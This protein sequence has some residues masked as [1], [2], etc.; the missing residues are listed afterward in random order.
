MKY[1]LYARKSTLQED[2]QV[3]SIDSQIND[4]KRKFSDI[5]EEDILVVTETKSAY[6]AYERKE[7]QKMIEL[8]EKGEYQGLLSYH[9]DRLSREPMSGAMIIHLLDQGHVKDLRFSS[10]HFHNSP[11]GKMMLALALSQ[12]K[13]FSEKLSGDVKRGMKDKCRLGSM[14]TRPPLGYMSD[15]LK[16]KGEK[17]YI[18]DP[19]RSDLVRKMWELML[20]NTYTPMEI[21]R[22]AQEWGLTSRPTKKH[23]QHLITKSFVYK[24][25]KNRVYTGYFEWNGDI[26]KG[27]YPAII[28]EVEFEKVQKMI[29]NKYIPRP[30]KYLSIYTSLM[31]C[32]CGSTMGQEIKQKFIQKDNHVKQFEYYRC[33]ARKKGNALCTQSPI[34]KNILEDKLKLFLQDLYIPD[35]IYKWAL[36]NLNEWRKN[37]TKERHYEITSQQKAYDEC[38]KKLDNLISLKISPANSNGELLSDDEFLGRKKEI[39]KERIHFKSCIDSSDLNVTKS[40]DLTMNTF[41]FISKLQ[42]SFKKA[43]TKEKKVILNTIGVK[44]VLTGEKID[45]TAKRPFMIIKKAINQTNEILA[46]CEPPYKSI[47]KTKNTLSGELISLWSG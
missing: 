30:Q 8:F 18:K 11:E 36:K 22:K 43:D 9:P 33:N 42:E 39:E 17:R 24:M 34:N 27:N 37:D 13:Y 40:I 35:S 21:T 7:F 4:I 25:F 41:D 16:E 47:N 23:P 31:Q 15:P 10:Y 3:L 2:R 46:R 28:T 45:I 12:S 14:P 26:Y 5:P 6:K 38:I 19:E 32:G 20:T 29:S 44:M 1:I